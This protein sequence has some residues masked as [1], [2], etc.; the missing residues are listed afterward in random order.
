[1]TIND[2]IRDEKRRYDVNWEAAEISAK[3]SGKLHKHEYL[4]G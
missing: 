1:M 3:S 4:T 2:Q